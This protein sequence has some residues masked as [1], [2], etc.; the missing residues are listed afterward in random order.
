M[1]SGFRINKQEVRKMTRALQRE[2]DRNPV[3][4]PVAGPSGALPHA[5]APSVTYNAPVVTVH[6]DNASIAWDNGTAIQ[7]HNAGP[8]AP[9]YEALAGLVNTLLSRLEHLHMPEDDDA[10]ARTQAKELLNEVVKPNPD[11]SIV[12][13]C[14]TM[15]NGLLTA[16]ITGAGHAVT[17]ETVDHT[18]TLIDQLIG[19]LPGWACPT[20][21]VAVGR[22]DLPRRVQHDRA[23]RWGTRSLARAHRRATRH[24]TTRPRHQLRPPPPTRTTSDRPPRKDNPAVAARHQPR[25]DARE[26]AETPR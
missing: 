16:A 12:K 20:S 13:R 19:A 1:P 8:V 14:V 25:R 24:P 15:L 10:E 6:G 2:L 23:A 5:G 21:S 4:L 7:T 22:R 11:R 18:R 3:R 17:T 26:R 9:G